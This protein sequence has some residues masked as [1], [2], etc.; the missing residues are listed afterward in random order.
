MDRESG[1]RMG[2]LVRGRATRWMERWK[3]EM[4]AS[5]LATVT[6]RRVYN[7]QKLLFLL[8]FPVGKI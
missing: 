4:S 2:G 8:I 6:L 7:F 1:A 5:G 3:R